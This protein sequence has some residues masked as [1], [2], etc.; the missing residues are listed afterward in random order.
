MRWQAA[1]TAAL[2]PDDP[3]TVG[4][5]AI[6]GRLGSGGEARV[7]LGS[8]ART[9]PVAVKVIRPRTD[10]RDPTCATEF[11]HLNRVETEFVSAPVGYGFAEAGPYLVTEHLAGTQPAGRLPA[12]RI[13]DRHLWR[14]AA[15]LA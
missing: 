13:G 3:T 8:S 14:I 10:D 7:Y 15:D 4:P 9:G 12:G 6:T 2:D 11:A 5:Y 1:Q